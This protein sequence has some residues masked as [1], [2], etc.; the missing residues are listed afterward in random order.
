M[1]EKAIKDRLCSDITAKSRNIFNGQSSANIWRRDP[2]PIRENLTRFG[3]GSD[4]T[5]P[6]IPCSALE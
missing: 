4:V 2:M 5:A 3:S 1:M 6:H